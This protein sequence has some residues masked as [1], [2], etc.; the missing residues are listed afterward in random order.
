MS[1]QQ[2]PLTYEGILEMFREARQELKEQSAEFDRRMKETDRQ[3]QKTDKKIAELGNRLGEI[4]EAMVEGGV[5][6]KFRDLGYSFSQCARH[7][8]FENRDIKVSGEIDLL[9]ED[10]GCVLAVEVKTNLAVDDIRDHVERLGKYRRYLDNK[11]DKRKIVAA[12]GG[13]VVLNN[14]KEFAWK[15]GMYTVIQSGEAV[16][17]VTPPEGFQ[18]KEW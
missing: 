5:V 4:I 8:S 12:A 10:G 13:G 14:V 9:L 3:M 17:I 2:Q 11:G 18:V 1:G 6:R 16:E 15:Q 7:V